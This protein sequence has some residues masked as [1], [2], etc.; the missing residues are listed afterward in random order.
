MRCCD[1]RHVASY[2]AACALLR[3]ETPFSPYV[4]TYMPM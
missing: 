3:A 4:A 2:I 1:V